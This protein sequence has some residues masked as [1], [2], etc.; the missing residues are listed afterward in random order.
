MGPAIQ[1]AR[2][3]SKEFL[4]RHL[5]LDYSKFDAVGHFLNCPDGLLFQH[6]DTVGL[7]SCSGN[8]VHI[9]EL[10]QRAF[11]AVCKSTLP[12]AA[13]SQAVSA[14]GEFESNVRDHSGYPTT[15]VIG[16]ELTPEYVGL[17]ASDVGMGVLESLKSNQHHQLLD[18]AGDALQLSIKE[19]VSRFEK[20]G[21]GNG[22]RPIFSG[23]AN[24]TG[25]LRFRSGNAVLE[26]SGFN[27]HRVTQEIKE[28]AQIKGLHIFVHCRLN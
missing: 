2:A 16:Y 9:E 23:L 18:D 27:Q 6:D 11:M 3:G 17:F 5:S 7:M 24:H 19:G 13:A 14:L 20:P 22:F 1:L 26:L 25:F 4:G 8:S 12:K 15:G 21:H 28:R 10:M